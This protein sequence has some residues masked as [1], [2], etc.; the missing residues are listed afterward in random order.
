[1]LAEDVFEDKEAA[2]VWMSTPNDALGGVTPLSLC[3][4]ELG[5]RQ[6]RRVLHA[7]EWGSAV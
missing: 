5:A 7:I 2:I 1:M 6:L 4:T 3:G